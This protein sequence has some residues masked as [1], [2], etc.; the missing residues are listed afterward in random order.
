VAAPPPV[1]APSPAAVAPG[2]APAPAADRGGGGGVQRGLGWLGVGLGAAG[3]VGGGVIGLVAKA[4][5]ESSRDGCRKQD[6]DTLC[7][8]SAIE[9]G[10]GARSMATAATITVGVGAA[11]LVGGIVVIV[12]AP[13]SRSGA[14]PAVTLT[15]RGGVG[16]GR[17]SVE[18]TW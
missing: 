15:A 14:G 2:T 8:A 11:L 7:N 5:Y 1:V 3:L 17:L 6:N 12:T 16:N 18:G 4:N 9:D 13:S 10:E